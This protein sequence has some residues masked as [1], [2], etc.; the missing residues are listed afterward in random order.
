MEIGICTAPPSEAGAKAMLAAGV[1]YY[2]PSVA[3]AIMHD[4]A[5]G[6]DAALASWGARG[7]SP[8]AANVLLPGDLSVVGPDVDRDRLETYLTEAMRRVRE[9]GIERVIFGSGTARNIPD[10]FPAE[11]GREQY[12]D[13]VRLAA[14]AAGPGVVICIEHL[15][16]QETNL[17]NLLSEAGRIA[18]EID[19]PNVGL[20]VDAYHLQ[21][22]AE[23]AGVVRDFPERVLH[24]HVCGPSRKPPAE[25]DVARFQDLFEHLAA[26]GYQ[27]R[28]SIECRWDD[29]ETQAAPGVAAVRAAADAA[30]L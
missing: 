16:K 13:A 14:A 24:V 4:D 19:L 8:R 29:L 7:L 12:A 20:V 9:L 30:G 28:C 1:A 27:G 11:Q 5:A 3:G 23:P 6:F 26:F 10:G 17:V 22:E 25:S 21:E 18:E 2:E 15:R